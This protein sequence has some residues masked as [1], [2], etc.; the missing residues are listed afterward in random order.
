MTRTEKPG[1]YLLG[2]Y[3]IGYTRFVSTRV[4]HLTR[5]LPFPVAVVGFWHL[6]W[7]GDFKPHNPARVEKFLHSHFKSKRLN[8]EWFSLS[9][10]DVATFGETISH[11]ASEL[12]LTTVRYAKRAK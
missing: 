8:G 6:Q 7:V 4:A 10:G 5:I 11:I 3:K 1:V 9:D 2:W 12:C